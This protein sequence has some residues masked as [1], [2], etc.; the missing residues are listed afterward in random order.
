MENDKLSLDCK[1][2]IRLLNL[3]DLK[4]N[5]YLLLKTSKIMISKDII[6][7]YH[8]EKLSKKHDLSHFSCGVKDLDDFLKEDALAQQEK[9]SECDLFGNP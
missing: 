2:K 8:Y 7:N 4:R 9:K 1:K 3:L 6:E 5:L